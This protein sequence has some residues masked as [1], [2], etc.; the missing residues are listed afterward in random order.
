MPTFVFTM[1]DVHSEKVRSYN[2]SR[3]KGKDTKPEMLVRRFLFSH[4]YRYRLHEKKLPGKPDIVLPKYNTAIFIHGC[5][6]HGH[7]DCR[8][9]IIPK[10]RTKWWLDKINRNKTLDNKAVELLEKNGWR[11]IIIWECDL[12]PAKVENRLSTLLTELKNG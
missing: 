5:F 6:W 9:F 4:G 1:A 11:V 8:Y 12:R 7:N 10:T 3:I 2:M